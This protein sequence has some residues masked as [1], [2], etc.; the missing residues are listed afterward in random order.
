VESITTGL[1]E[2]AWDDPCT[3][4]QCLDDAGDESKVSWL[5]AMFPEI[6]EDNICYRLRKCSGNLTRTIDELLNL[7]FIDQKEP[8]WQSEV[9]KSID[10]FTQ[11]EDLSR[12]RKGKGKGKCRPRTI[13]STRS[14]ST[15]S[16]NGDTPRESQNVW[17]SMAGDVEFICSKTNLDPQTVR[18]MYN[19]E[20]KSLGR[21]ISWLGSK[22]G[23]RLES[24]GALEPV[25]QA[26]LAELR[27]DF[28]AFPDSL[29]YGLLV[30]SGNIMSA[31][32]ELAAVVMGSPQ[33]KPT[34]QL[35]IIRRYAPIEL[36]P[37]V[38]SADSNPQSP[39]SWSLVNHS[40]T[41]SLAMAK[42]AAAST[43]FAQAND[44]HKRGKSDHLMG[45]AAAYHAA[46]AHEKLKAAKELSAHAANGLVM[47]QSTSR[48]LDL[49]GVSVADAVRIAR[50]QVALWWHSLGDTKYAS[51]GGGPAREGYRVV[52]GMGRH[53]RDGT[54]KIGP[55]VSRMLVREGWKVTVGQGEILI[56][57]KARR[58]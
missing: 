21:T 20:G 17:A 28:P 51:G 7:A 56:T 6:M 43:A 35:Q 15:A 58:S 11:I 52:T 53:S 22:E 10:G 26:Q 48:M 54:P 8:G 2:L 46:V 3:E 18:A 32:H 14:N 36:G 27:A 5:K 55:A 45:G 13:D 39:A 31:A 42:S 1:S 23:A 4:G 19:G 40:K 30:V 44:D 9:P 47:S 34:G 38:E 33:Q 49:H 25:E 16:M 50:E 12:G 41:R 37:D 24:V 29:L 57:G